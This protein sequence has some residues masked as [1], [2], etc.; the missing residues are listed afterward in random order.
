MVQKETNSAMGAVRNHLE[1]EEERKTIKLE[2]VTE[3]NTETDATEIILA[4]MNETGLGP[5]FINMQ[6]VVTEWVY[7]NLDDLKQML[8]EWKE[9]HSKLDEEDIV[10]KQWMNTLTKEEIQSRLLELAD[11]YNLMLDTQTGYCAILTSVDRCIGSGAHPGVIILASKAGSVIID[12]YIS[13]IVAM[14]YEGMRSGEPEDINTLQVRRRKLT[15]SELRYLSPSKPTYLDS[16]LVTSIAELGRPLY[17]LDIQRMR[18]CRIDRNCDFEDIEKYIDLGYPIITYSAFS[19]AIIDTTRVMSKIVS[20]MN[21]WDSHIRYR[22]Q[23]KMM[24]RYIEIVNDA[25]CTE[26]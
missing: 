15:L 24:R 6:D 3:S 7:G 18:N 19:A 5:D 2:P 9:K 22:R 21:W 20:A 17:H 11:K 1:E 8:S 23:Y 10:N 4:K 26:V 13:G 14:L 12:R 25:F 16:E